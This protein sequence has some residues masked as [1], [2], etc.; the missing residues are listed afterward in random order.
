M[1]RRARRLTSDRRAHAST[2]A[3]LSQTG[4]AT[5]GAYRLSVSPRIFRFSAVIKSPRDFSSGGEMFERVEVGV[6]Q[7]TA[8]P[9][10]NSQRLV[11][12]ARSLELGAHG[13]SGVLRSSKNSSNFG[14]D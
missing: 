1:G 11:E 2:L 13:L 6:A 9:V 10:I 8:V 7:L 12:V 3:G 5:L 4:K 14:I